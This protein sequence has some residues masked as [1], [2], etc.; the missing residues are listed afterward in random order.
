[1]FA[2]RLTQP[3]PTRNVKMAELK[4]LFERTKREVIDGPPVSNIELIV[5][6]ESPIV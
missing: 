5:A 4:T 6:V 3:P 1:M 2:G